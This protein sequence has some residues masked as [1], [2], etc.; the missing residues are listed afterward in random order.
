MNF[1]GQNDTI[2]ALKQLLPRPECAR[3]RAGVAI[4]VRMG[5]LSPC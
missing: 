4:Q 1:V 2:G 5:D 3:T